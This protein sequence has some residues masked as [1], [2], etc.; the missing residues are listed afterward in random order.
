MRRWHREQG[1]MVIEAT[2]VFPVVFF[3]IFFLIYFGNVFYL[4]SKVESVTDIVAVKGASYYT[5]P[6]LTKIKETGSAPTRFN[7]IRPYRYWF[8]TASVESEMRQELAQK[9]GEVGT[10][11]FVGMEPETAIQTV[12]FENHL[13]YDTFVVEVSYKVQFPIRFI[14]SRDH[15]VLKMNSK[16][17]ASAADTD[18]FIRN[19]DMVLDYYESTGLKDKVQKAVE[20]VKEFFGH[21][22][23]MKD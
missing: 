19:T 15:M 23:Q 20:K 17:I 18:N 22:S 1:E 16:A 11:F 4:R 10:G 9:L 2:L 5:D 13:F 12:A 21:G 8:K 14:G 6:M 3:V 7:D